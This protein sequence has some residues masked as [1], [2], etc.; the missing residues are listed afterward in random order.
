M[1]IL[2]SATPGDAACLRTWDDDPDVRA[3]AGSD[4]VTDWEAEIA[5][6]AAWGESLIAEID[7]RPIGFVRII[8]PAKEESHYWGEVGPGL[9]AV[10]IWVGAAADRGRG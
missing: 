1:L 2:R 6:Q 7:G 8:D 3:A 10:D 5:R 4:G 9:R